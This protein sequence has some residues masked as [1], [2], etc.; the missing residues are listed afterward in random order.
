MSPSEAAADVGRIDLE[1]I[2]ESLVSIVREMRQ[3]VFRT[4]HS[5]VIADAQDFSCALFGPTGEMVAQG[6]DMPGHV[7]A[8]PASVAE[9]LAD[10]GSEM[11]PGDLYVVNDPY[12]GGSHLNDV[13]LIAPVF[14]EGELFLFPCVRMHWADIGGMTPGSVSGQATEIFQE[15]VRIPPIRLI[16]RGEENRAAMTILFANVRMPDERR[17]DLEAGIAACRTAERRLQ[18]L[19]E[20]YGG[21]LV[22]ACMAANMDRTERRLRDRIAA[23][24][25]RTYRYED[26]LDLYT[27]GRYDAAQIRCEL[28]IAGEEIVADFRGSSPQSPAVVNASLAMTRAGV[29]IAVKSAL[30][31]GGMINHGA[32]RPLTVRT[33]PGTV[34]HAAYPAPV[35]A[36]SEVRKRVISVVMAA[37]SQAAPDLV[38]ADQCGTTF[39]NL[40]GGVDDAS[41]LPYL[42]Y[43]YP[44]GG[45]G[46]FAGSDGPSAMN[47][48]DLG[49]ISTIQSVERLETEVPVLIEACEYRVDSGGPGLR[50]GGLGAIRATRLL[51][52]AGTYSVQTDRTTVPP[53][54]LLGGEPGAST[55]TH[56]RSGG[57]RIDFDTPGKVA[58]FR[59]RAGDV[60]VMES[61]GGGG[62]G[63]PLERE[64][65]LV[66]ADV[67]Q[68]LV[69]TGQALARYGVVLSSEDAPDLA[70]TRRRRELMRRQETWM[71]IAPLGD[72]PGHAGERGRQRLVYLHPDSGL[73]ERALVELQGEHPAPLRAWVSW[74]PRV[75]ERAVAIE[76]SALQVLGSSPGGRVRAR[77]LATR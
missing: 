64:P 17:G 58:G 2:T 15:G 4:A 68:G 3:T 12:R 76:D 26:Y 69:T 24:P 39:Q 75:S 56:V 7:I 57:K 20:R 25:D 9:V 61:A 28:T 50:R 49:D 21:S 6:R 32:F 55:G 16:D 10:F 47:P 73:P 60:L 36:H 40:L 77:V 18:E 13:T 38:A 54:G 27:E 19:A 72:R 33:D 30:D 74:D 29:F 44:A 65:E 34:V 48:V 59:M 11:R 71:K 22:L 35:N 5:P 31:P 14:L 43:D 52:S 70:L 66:A 42:Y 37:L 41:G 53:Y 46:G 1:V 63:D 45:N 23:L 8:M 62:W 51:A 67:A